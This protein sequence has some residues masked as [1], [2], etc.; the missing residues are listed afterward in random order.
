L[1]TP[2]NASHHII[3]GKVD[4]IAAA[5]LGV[6]VAGVAGRTSAGRTSSMLIDQ[7][8]EQPAR[9]M[10]G[11]AIRHELDELAGVIR[12]LGDEKLAA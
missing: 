4:G 11:H 8:A 6:V 3:P 7:K 5:A 9:T 12:T 2:V 10:L 1:F